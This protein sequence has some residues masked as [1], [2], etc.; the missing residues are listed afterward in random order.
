[1]V[2]CLSSKY[3]AKFKPQHWGKKIHHYNNGTIARTTEIEP[4]IYKN[5]MYDKGSI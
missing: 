5:L 1:M 3:E 2:D 4:C